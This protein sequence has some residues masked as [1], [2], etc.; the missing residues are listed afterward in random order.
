ML[1]GDGNLWDSQ[2]WKIEFVAQFHNGY[3]TTVMDYYADCVEKY[4]D[5]IKT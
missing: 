5:E 1:E 4:D 2:N 3:C